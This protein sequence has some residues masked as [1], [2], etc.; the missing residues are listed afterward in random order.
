MTPARWRRLIDAFHASLERPPEERDVFLA[1]TCGADAELRAALDRMLAAHEQAGDFLDTPAGGPPDRLAGMGKTLG[2]YELGACLG[3]GGMGHV[4]QAYDSELRR[5]VAIKFMTSRDPSAQERLRREAR[6]ASGLNHPNIC[7]IH[8]IGDAEGHAYIVMEHL[9]G[10]PLCEVIPSDGLSL[11]TALSYARQ[12]ADAVAHAH[13]RGIVHRDIKSSNVMV[14][15]DGHVKVLD[16][17]IS[18]RMGD[19][20]ATKGARTGTATSADDAAVVGTLGYMAPELLR[21]QPA[22]PRSDVW[23][24]GVLLSEML[25]GHRPFAGDT[26]F[27]LTSAIL[28][29]RRGPLPSGIPGP[30]AAIVGRCLSEDA[31]R[32]P[33]TA[34]LVKD[35]LAAPVLDIPLPR[36]GAMGVRDR[37]F[38][39]AGAMVAL[40]FVA[41]AVWTAREAPAIAPGAPRS[42]AVLPFQSFGGSTEDDYFL[43]GMTESLITDLAKRKDLLVIGRNSVFQYKGEAVDVRQVGQ[44]LGVRYVLEG[45]VQRSGDRL[46]LNAQLIDTVTGYHLWADRYDRDADDVFALQD[47]ISR[48]IA[49][50]L[51]VALDPGDTKPPTR[52]IEA[53]DAY[54][55]GV[56]LTWQDS[57]SSNERAIPL[58]EKAVALDPGFALAHA[59]MAANY[60]QIF[61]NFDPTRHWEEKAHVALQKAL[62]LEPDLPEAHHTRGM[63]TWTLSNGFPHEA[64][65]Q[66]IRRAIAGKP[67]LGEAHR[68]LCNIYAHIGLLD[69]AL[70]ECDAARRIDPTAVM[71]RSATGMAL[72]HQNRYGDLL[73]LREKNPEMYTPWLWGPALMALGREREAREMVEAAIVKRPQDSGLHGLNALLLARAGE[74]VRAQEM[75]GRSLDLGKGLGHI[76]HT[77]HLV[78]AAYAAMGRKA[79]ALDWL[80]RASAEGFPCFPYFEKDPFLDPLRDDPRFQRWLRGVKEQWQ[81][82][83]RALA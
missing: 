5:T 10:R 50:A 36:Q 6:H 60:R 55:Q 63:L 69:E 19:A 13:E 33:A 39:W 81:E 30:L 40:L 18:R 73:A 76:H 56:Y 29:N 67:S 72:L 38:G 20:F 15:V 25:T 51:E 11:E 32:R 4:Y 64:A 44:E 43:D 68:Q 9:T 74:N 54:L 12:V 65:I 23:A 53:Y 83:R 71:V 35:A 59:A 57:P 61:H 47:D 1:E 26:P 80:E 42:I 3:I 49:M 78:G 34:A 46:R 66:D 45:S 24:M 21:G 41:G 22:S 28:E 31:S 70:A 48:K 52:N 62:A 58:L 16:F 2:H 75:I 7:I 27:E 8:H 82:L 14:G 37:A 17:G 77:Q 79:D